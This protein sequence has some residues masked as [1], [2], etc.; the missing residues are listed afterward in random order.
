MSHTISPRLAGSACMRP[1]G[2]S[3]RMLPLR[4]A[5]EPKAPGPSSHSPANN[6]GLTLL[7]T[8]RIT[9]HVVWGVGESSS[10]RHA[11]S[12]SGCACTE[13]T[14]PQ[15]SYGAGWHIAARGSSSET[16]EMDC[17]SLCPVAP[18]GAQQSGRFCVAQG[19]TPVGS[20][21]PPAP[22]WREHEVAQVEGG[23]PLS[24]GAWPDF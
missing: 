21:F 6:I 20:H 15:T 8:H 14:P 22:T 17:L 13:P 16:G 9:P 18:N 24:V 11:L 4:L 19:K 7:R 10:L 1:R 5:S 12:A 23:E 3:T 2:S